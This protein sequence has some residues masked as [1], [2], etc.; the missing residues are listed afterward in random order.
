MPH[1]QFL[2]WLNLNENKITPILKFEEKFRKEIY[3]LKRRPG[4]V[5]KVIIIKNFEDKILG[6]KLKVDDL[7]ERVSYKSLKMEP[8]QEN[9][10]NEDAGDEHWN[11]AWCSIL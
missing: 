1:T 8:I 11:P 7:K 6:V 2:H 4:Y 10:V 5:I 3:E 9:R